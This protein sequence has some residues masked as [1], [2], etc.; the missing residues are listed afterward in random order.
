[1]VQFG[2]IPPW[3]QGKD[4]LHTTDPHF[5]SLKEN[6]DIMMHRGKVRATRVVAMS[7]DGVA[8]SL[9]NRDNTTNMVYLPISMGYRNCYKC[10]MAGSGYKVRSNPNRPIIVEAE[11]EAEVDGGEG[12]DCVSI[13]FLEE[14]VPPPQDLQASQGHSFEEDIGGI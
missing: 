9:A 13:E 11:A 1:M 6:F 3:H 5:K 4:R 8:R 10:Y 2:S 12:K 7:V 14:G